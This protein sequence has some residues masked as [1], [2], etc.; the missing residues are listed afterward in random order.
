MSGEIFG[1]HIGVAADL[2]LP[3]CYAVF[4][5][6]YIYR[7]L[8]GLQCLQNQTVLDLNIT[9]DPILPFN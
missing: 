4:L 8:N 1:S 6:I 5:G 3:E 2:A 7:R 9:E